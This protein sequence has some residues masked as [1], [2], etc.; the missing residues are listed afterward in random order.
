MPELPEVES[1]RQNVL[2]FLEKKVINVFYINKETKLFEGK[3]DFIKEKIEGQ[4]VQKLNRIG[5]H[6]LIHLNNGFTLYIHLGVSG[7]FYHGKDSSDKHAHFILEN[8]DKEKIIYRDPRRFGKI[9][10]YETKAEKKFARLKN[11]GTDALLINFEEFYKKIKEKNRAIKVALLDQ[12][13]LAGVGNIY[14]DEALFST[15]ILPTKKTKDI[16]KETYQQLLINIKQILNASIA[17]KGSSVTYAVGGTGNKGNFQFSLNVYRRDKQKCNIC[18]SP[19]QKMKLG[20][21][22]THY[23]LCCQK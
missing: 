21:R 20:G 9:M 14:A 11:I 6:L 8:E 13:V 1:V 15:N 2:P 4:T 16:P 19:I 3:E 22:G 17:A 18:S 10:V 5:K 7:Q 23:C 12:A